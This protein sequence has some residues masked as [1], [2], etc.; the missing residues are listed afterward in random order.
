[1]ITV[2]TYLG[3][4][5][6]EHGS[7]TWVSAFI[8][9][10]N[11]LAG[12][13]AGKAVR[14]LLK[15]E[16]GFLYIQTANPS[17]SSLVERGEGFTSVFRDSKFRVI[18]EGYD[19][20]SAVKATQQVSAILE[21]Y[22]RNLVILATNLFSAAGAATAVENMNRQGL[23]TVVAFDSTQ[24]SMRYLRAKSVDLVVGQFPRR[25]GEKSVQGM[26]KLF[27]DETIP[28]MQ[29]MDSILITRDNMDSSEAKAA[30]YM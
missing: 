6:Y 23:Q 2:D 4:G 19:E 13:Q 20:G 18:G 30:I 15:E 7:L 27:Q 14:A 12:E 9:T 22:P 26:V 24:D 5:D 8:G 29:P 11:R 25:M 10:Q 17:A 21:R 28:K 16:T 1:V 3:N